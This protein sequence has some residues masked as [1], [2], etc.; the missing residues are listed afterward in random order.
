M[1]LILPQIKFEAIPFKDVGGVAFQADTDAD[2]SDQI[3]GFCLKSF[4]LVAPMGLTFRFPV[5]RPFQNCIL[6]APADLCLLS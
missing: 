6:L 4:P 1:T 2:A 3:L 5:K